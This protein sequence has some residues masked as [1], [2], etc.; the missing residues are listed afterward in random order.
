MR[1]PRTVRFDISDTR[2]YETAAAPDE[3]AVSGAFVFAAADPETLGGKQRQAF[4]RGFLGTASFGWSTFVAVAEISEAEFEQV[5][6][7]LAGHAVDRYGAPDVEAAL[8]AARE[9][10]DFAAGLCDHK[11]NTVLC[12]ERDV[13]D[14]GIVERFRVVEPP[15]E[16]AHAR[17][18]TLVE[19]DG[20]V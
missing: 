8:P 4:V 19:D 17:I 16:P 14:E 9:E 15:R 5:V 20:S 1:F 6:L 2:I 7:A 12:V 3:W 10:A 18:W 13:G 11:V